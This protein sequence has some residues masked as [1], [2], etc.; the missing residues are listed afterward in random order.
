MAQQ[1][2]VQ[3]TPFWYNFLLTC[4]KPLYRWKIKQRAESDALYQQECVERFGP[5]QP[6]KNLATIWFHVVS[7]GETN[8]AQPLI[9]HY[10]KLGHPVLVTNTTKT[11]QA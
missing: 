8:A 6:P 11:G 7:V 9:E 10:L 4:L 1:N 2:A 3:Q 5:F